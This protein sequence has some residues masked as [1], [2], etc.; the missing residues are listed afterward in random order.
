MLAMSLI[1]LPIGTVGDIYMPVSYQIAVSLITSV[2][3]R[4][5]IEIEGLNRV[6]IRQLS[7]L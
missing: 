1:R 6:S 2:I 7:L 3:I 4:F 5:L